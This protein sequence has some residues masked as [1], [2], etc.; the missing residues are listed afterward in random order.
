MDNITINGLTFSVTTECDYDA[1]APW[2]REDGHGPVRKLR[3]DSKRP[4]ERILHSERHYGH[5]YD[6]AEAMRIAKRDGWGL[7]PEAMGDLTAKLGREPTAG[8]VAAAAVE[9]DFQRLRD[10]CND[11]WGYVGVV[12]TLQDTD[13]DDTHEC[14]SLWGIESDAHAYLEEIAQELAETLAER[15]GGDTHITRGAKRWQVR[16]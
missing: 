2:D 6:F 1:E 12:V 13:G 10:W 15:I 9:L 5:A 7:V 16:A 8:E 3:T 14:E 4:G 11:R